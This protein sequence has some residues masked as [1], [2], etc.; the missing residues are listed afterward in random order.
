MQRK[1]YTTSPAVAPAVA[2]LGSESA[3]TRPALPHFDL[4]FRFVGGSAAVV[5]QDSIDD[6]INCVEA[7]VRTQRGERKEIPTFGV[8]EM[9]FQD[10]P[11]D[12]RSFSAQIVEHEPRATLLFEQNPHE[13][14]AIVAD[15][16]MTVSSGIESLR[17]A[18]N[19]EIIGEG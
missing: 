15:V 10:Q 12:T 5:E 16:R 3:A 9:T 14:D 2:P 8:Y 6:V 7:A 17:V 18:A 13:F 1:L 4:P 11:V 19:P